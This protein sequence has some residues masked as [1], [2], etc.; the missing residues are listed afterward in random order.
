[1]REME[2][3]QLEQKLLHGEP[4]NMIDVREVKE[5]A[6][7][8]IPGVMNIPLGLLQFRIHEL[9][10][11]KE[12]IIIC[13]SGGRSAKATQFLEEHGYKAINMNGGMLAWK[14]ETE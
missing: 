13:R 12:Y 5:V 14:G 8:K 4:V 10:K 3:K 2:V 7:G 6:E 9:D 1:M 11:E